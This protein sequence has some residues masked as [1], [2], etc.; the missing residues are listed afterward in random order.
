[1][2]WVGSCAGSCSCVSTVG[3]EAALA[4]VGIQQARLPC[5][6]IGDVYTTRVLEGLPVGGTETRAHKSVMD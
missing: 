5:I 4:R 2:N 1:M 6:P 3:I